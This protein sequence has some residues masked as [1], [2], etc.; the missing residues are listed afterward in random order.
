MAGVD[1]ENT[2]YHPTATGPTGPVSEKW[3][4][5]TDSSFT[6]G[7]AVVDGVAYIGDRDWMLYAVD[8]EDGS[9]RWS[10]ELPVKLM[11]GTIAVAEEIICG[12]TGSGGQFVVTRRTGEL[13]WATNA[14][15]RQITGSPTISGGQIYANTDEG[16]VYSIDLNDGEINWNIEIGYR[17]RKTIGLSENMLYAVGRNPDAYAINL[18]TKEREWTAQ[19][20]QWTMGLAIGDKMIYVGTQSSES[21]FGLNKDSGEIQ[22]E[23]DV[24]AF[25]LSS[26]SYYPGYVIAGTKKGIV[27]LDEKTG[28]KIWNVEYGGGKASISLTRN[29]L[30][31]GSSEGVH[32]LNINTGEEIWRH[33]SIGSVR[34]EIAV[35]DEMLI[36]SSRNGNLYALG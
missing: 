18:E 7:A 12:N 16:F 6:A 21:I 24:G 11:N 35:I 19:L 5:E 26:I 33:E 30:Y 1:L 28:E 20:D 4:F 25:V 22:W 13:E 29:R 36:V 10:T 15:H 8:L 23:Q 3:V 34:G 17:G 27:C 31:T 9:E 2:G 32:C 14:Y